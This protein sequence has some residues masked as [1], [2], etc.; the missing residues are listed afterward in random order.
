[1][2]LGPFGSPNEAVQLLLDEC[3]VGGIFLR[4]ASLQ[5]N[6]DVYVRGVRI[7]VKYCRRC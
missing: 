5:G 2:Y 3:W 4:K 1:M 6:R 7:D